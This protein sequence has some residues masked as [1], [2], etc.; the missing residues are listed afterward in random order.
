MAND[1]ADYPG[2]DV[3]PFRNCYIG[4]AGGLLSDGETSGRI[5]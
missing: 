2:Y 4:D 1:A 3:A 5:S